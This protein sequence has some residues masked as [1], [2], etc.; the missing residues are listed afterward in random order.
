[1]S[2]PVRPIEDGEW[3]GA[4][5]ILSLAQPHDPWSAAEL[6]RR[7]QEQAS[8]GYTAGVLVAVMD[9]EVRGMAAYG[10][11]PGAYHPQRYVLELAVDPAHGGQ[12]VGGALWAALEA[13][14]RGHDARQ[15]RILARGDHPVA[16]GFLAR[17]GFTAGKRYFTSALDVTA[18]DDSPYRDLPGRLAAQG[19]RI[20]SLAQLRAAGTPDL[21][22]RLHA[23]M[24]DV[25]GDVPRDD[26][27]TPLSLQ[28]FTDA[29]LGDPGL[30]PEAYLV[31]EAGGEWIGQTVL[32]RSGASPELG[33][34]LTGVTRGWR[35]R[36]VATALKVAAIG[37]ARGLSAPTIRTDNA[38]DNVPMLRVND[39]LGFVRDPATVSFLRVF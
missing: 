36:G 9:G 39:R 3:E 30:L 10:Q 24:S 23:L 2:V 17:R 35:G 8:W 12:G 29:V 38:S 34:G 15:A 28:V 33:T 32:F 27:A 4:A 22:T 20:R 19:A 21:D 31:A 6:H 37:V 14:L 1:M 11:N 26:P 18:F 7:G 13:A 25:R 5:R 16:P